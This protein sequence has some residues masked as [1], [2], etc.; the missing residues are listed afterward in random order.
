VGGATLCASS[1]AAKDLK[2]V[3]DELLV[4]VVGEAESMDSFELN[5]IAGAVLAA[6]LT[7]FGVKTLLDIGF[8]PHKLKKPAYEVAVTETSAVGGAAA[9]PVAKLPI[10]ELIKVGT[11]E[12]GKDVF[13]KC[14]ACHTPEKGGTHKQGPNL[15]GIIGRDVGKVDGAKYSDAMKA[16][17]GKWSFEALQT[18]L[19]DPKGSIPGNIM[20]FGGV[21]DNADLGSVLVYLNTLADA[22]GALPK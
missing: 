18:Y 1:R 13:K 19:Y 16:K 15:Y 6:L 12:N 7:I 3:S 5:K 21:K 14:A 8:T 11:L 17:G 20:A 2:H 4:N 10:A 9:A 22:P